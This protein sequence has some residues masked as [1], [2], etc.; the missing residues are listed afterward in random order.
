MSAR[1]SAAIA[2]AALVP[3]WVYAL[4]IAGGVTTAL[5][6]SICVLLIAGGLYLMFGPHEETRDVNRV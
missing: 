2:L 1:R 6:S 3:V 5:T 4:T